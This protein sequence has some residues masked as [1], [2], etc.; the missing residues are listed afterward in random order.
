[1]R[2]LCI[3]GGGSFD[4][5][6][7]TKFRILLNYKITNWL[8]FVQCAIYAEVLLVRTNL[9]R[10]YKMRQMKVEPIFGVDLRNGIHD[11]AETLLYTE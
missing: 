7:Y 11:S 8:G 2:R 5:Y 9:I 6:P 10:T 4:G 1:M 3:R